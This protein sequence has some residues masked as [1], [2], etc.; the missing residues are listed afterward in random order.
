MCDLE[1]GRWLCLASNR[2]L[3]AT[4]SADAKPRPGPDGLIRIWL[5]RNSV[6]RLGHMRGPGESHSDVILP[7]FMRP[8]VSMMISPGPAEPV[9]R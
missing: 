6:D 9:Y 2:H 3:I 5:D 1:C 8:F 4:G 7:T